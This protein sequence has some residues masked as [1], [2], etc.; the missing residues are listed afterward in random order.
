[1]K[2]QDQLQYIDNFLEGNLE[3]KELR[4]LVY[5]LIHDESLIRNFRVH[6]SMKGAFV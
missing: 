1:M 6:T 4:K 5:D 3:K 2:K